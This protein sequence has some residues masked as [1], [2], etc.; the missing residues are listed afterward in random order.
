LAE[1]LSMRCDEKLMARVDAAIR[2]VL[3]M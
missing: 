2:D 3:E 1:G